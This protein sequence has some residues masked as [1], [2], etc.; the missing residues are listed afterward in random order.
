MKPAWFS[1]IL[2]ALLFLGCLQV[3]DVI[4]P[5]A[6]VETWQP[7]DNTIYVLDAEDNIERELLATSE[8]QYYQLLR[9]ARLLTESHNQDHPLD[10]WHQVNGPC[11][12]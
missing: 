12:Y 5:D 2:L 7:E 11:T 10:P 3:M 1:L 9:A 8:E 4:P 6:P